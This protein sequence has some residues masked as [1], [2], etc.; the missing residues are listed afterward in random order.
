MN[1]SFFP[2]Q[3]RLNLALWLPYYL[4]ETTK[5]H[6]KN[7]SVFYMLFNDMKC[8]TKTMSFST[9]NV[10]WHIHSYI[11]MIPFKTLIYKLNHFFFCHPTWG[12]KIPKLQ[13]VVA[14]VLVISF[15]P[16]HRRLCN[17]NF[18]QAAVGLSFD[19]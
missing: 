1:H 8:S 11:K 15:V 5:S 4:F 18:W 7:L 6:N 12:K 17:Y 10:L 2:M 9:K 13:V 19:G 3:T 14:V 16:F